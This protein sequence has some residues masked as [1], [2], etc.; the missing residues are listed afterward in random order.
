MQ[1]WIIVL[2]VSALASTSVVLAKDVSRRTENQTNTKNSASE[3]SADVLFAY[4][5]KIG[6][7]INEKLRHNYTGPS[8][9]ATVTFNINT[10]GKFSNIKVAET[11]KNPALDKIALDTVASCSPA[12][13]P[14]KGVTKPIPFRMGFLFSAET[15]GN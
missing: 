12:G 11:T 7:M 4:T 6:I 13:K 3:P 14:P 2:L 15:R 10:D 9:Q 8:K 5:S 1:K